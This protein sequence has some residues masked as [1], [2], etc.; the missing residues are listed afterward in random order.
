MSVIGRDI[1]MSP[2]FVSTTCT[3]WISYEHGR[4]AS[5]HAK[6]KVREMEAIYFLGF[7][8]Y[9]TR[10]RKGN[11]MV[12]RKTEKSRLRR[13]KL[14]LTEKMKEIR[15]WTIKVQSR[16]INEMLRGQYNYYGMGR[17]L[18]SLQKLYNKA[19]KYWWKLLC[20][21]S[22]KGYITWDKYN[23]LKKEYPLL[24]PKVHISYGKM[25]SY[26]KL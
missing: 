6:E 5:R 14:K 18:G 2:G 25:Q 24:H 4:F 7:T 3:Q 12:G 22:W 20:S 17:N 26:A 11:F 21:R 16:K 8:H 23:A 10:N 9:C 13:S 1:L 15:H 19:E